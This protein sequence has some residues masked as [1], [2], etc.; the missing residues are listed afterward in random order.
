M[1]DNVLYDSRLGLISIPGPGLPGCL[2]LDLD[3][4]F[5]ISKS[6]LS[7]K[8]IV[9]GIRDDY[10]GP[11]ASFWWNSEHPPTSSLVGRREGRRAITTPLV[12][13]PR[14]ALFARGGL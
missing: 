6:K 3:W 10:A 1:D 4:L 8:Q 7:T 5:R 14:P 9:Y 11:A 12:K 2:L 13:R